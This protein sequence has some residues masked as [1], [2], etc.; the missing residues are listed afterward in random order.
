MEVLGAAGP[1]QQG[2]SE[3]LNR[4]AS[5]TRVARVSLSISL[6]AIMVL[7]RASAMPLRMLA[8]TA[9]PLPRSLPLR[10]VRASGASTKA[11]C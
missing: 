6:P 2:L 8:R 10:T 4:S 7:L 3:A 9:F 5:L 11:T 1:L